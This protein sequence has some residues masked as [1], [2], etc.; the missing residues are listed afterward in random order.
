[1]N[2]TPASLIILVFLFLF[3]LSGYSQTFKKTVQD[4][5]IYNGSTDVKD[6]YSPGLEGNLQG[7]PSTQ[8][9]KVYLPPGYANFPNNR[10][11]VLYLL[12]A[13]THDYNA[14]Y[15]SY[16]L[17]NTV[18][19]LIFTKTI[20]PMIIVT[21]NAKTIYDGSFYM[22]SYVSGNWEDFIVQDVITHVESNYW[23]L[24]QQSSRA[25]SGFSMGGFGT[26]YLGLKH[27]SIF[28]AIAPIGAPCLDFNTNY[29][30]SPWKE[31]LTECAIINQYRPDD[32]WYTR[33]MYALAVAVAPDSTAKPIMGLL[34]YNSEG[35]LVDSIWQQWLQ[36]DPSLMLP[37]LKD[38][39]FK[40]DNA[41]QIYI[42]DNDDLLSNNE[43]FHQALL[44]NGIDH[45]YE[46]YSGGHNPE[47][48][49]ENLLFYVSE[50][51]E[52]AVPTVISIGDNYYMDGG[53]T[54]VFK[55]DMNG[56]LYFIPDTVYPTLDSIDKYKSLTAEVIADE[57]KEIKLSE[58]EL[59]NY[60]V[61]GI[62]NENMVSIIPEAFGVVDYV[63]EFL[64][65]V[66]DSYT[67]EELSGCL[68]YLNGKQFIKESEDELNLTGWA[69]DTC[70]I[71]ITKGNYTDFDTTVVVR[72]DTSFVINLQFAHPEAELIVYNEPIV[73]KTDL[74]EMMMNQHGII[75]LT[76]EGTPAVADSIIEN[77]II[78]YSA[79]AEEKVIK[80]LFGI[81][82][83]IYRIYGISVVGRIATESYVVQV[84]DH[85]PS[86]IVHVKDAVSNE[87]LDSCVLVVDE[88]DTIPGPHGE[89]DLTGYY[90]SCSIVVSRE[91]YA[92]L[93][94]TFIVLSDTT[95]TIFLTSAT[96]KNERLVSQI[97]IFPNPI[98]TLL[99]IET[100]IS[101][102]Y[103]IEIT[104]L[105]G[106]LIL[107]RVLD[108]NS[109]R[110]DLASFQTGV[111][112]ITIRSKDFVTT[113]K[114]IK[115]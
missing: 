72:T 53:D 57:E 3:T 109:Y 32:P 4:S 7:N 102:L 114:I 59:G 91:G 40:Y 100:V 17:L 88:R 22:N 76:P 30:P 77:A 63:P 54:L 27:H 90:D 26:V 43:T 58:F 94:T 41:I 75:Y 85:F 11:P 97:Q 47:P 10:Y 21:P 18:N 51:L 50:S 12:H 70:L 93:D 61:Y 112:F 34:P 74:L 39:L 42:G 106:Q 105:N 86:C 96:D 19:N 37:E 67:M 52:G 46:I 16:D 108:G 89:F 99:N 33:A 95:F 80:L 82:P 73:E 79:N 14:F 92:D 101:T 71:Q 84:I 8:P 64:I 104:S 36:Y 65:Q 20:V 15:D 83:G 113:R 44:D 35:E 115:L 48:V 9:V 31:R 5:P 13:Y 68:I 111:Y 2:R 62:S 29:L 24:S 45:G 66:T 1:M 25:I 98:N 55:S 49:I 107:S 56:Q 28:K 60:L 38:S 81:P 6:V 69:Y 87:F 110:I 78:S 103:D 23:V